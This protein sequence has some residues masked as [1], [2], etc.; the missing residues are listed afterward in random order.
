MRYY[1]KNLITI[2]TIL[3]VVS[4]GQQHKNEYVG[5]TFN[6]PIIVQPTT[7]DTMEYFKA[8]YITHS[9]SDFVGKS[10]F[11]DTL[12]LSIRRDGD[13]LIYNEDFIDE[14][15]IWRSDSLKADGLEL[16]PDY[17]ST[18]SRI[19]HYSRKGGYFYPV[20]I[21]NQTPA[22]KKF[23]GKDSYVFAIQE[24]LDTNRNWRPIEGRGF[25]FC[26]NGYWG[27]KIHPKEFLTILMPKYQ[28]TFKT[29][30]RVRIKIG[31]IIYVS[32]PFE[33]TINERQ[34]YLD[35]ED[36]YHYKQ[37]V[38]NRASAIQHLFYGAEPLESQD[39][40]FGLHVVWTQ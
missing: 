6:F 20:Y 23:I 30:I 39:E 13:T 5:T 14:G 26:G 24:A 25:D 4:C 1:M 36:G 28:G 11:C 21:V 8:N 22:T 15:E 31:D 34:F 29:K 2:L 37:L 3:A 19:D 33:G 40:N 18:V 32:N 17:K 12:K 10:K 16:F 7:T 27:L 9:W 35:K 38:A